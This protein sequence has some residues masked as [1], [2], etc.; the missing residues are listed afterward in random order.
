[1]TAVSPIGPAYDDGVLRITW[2]PQVNGFRLEGTVDV[3]NRSGLA[4]ALV[5]AQQGCGHVLI[6]LAALEFIDM[7]GLRLLV[8]AAR[9]LPAGRLLVLQRVPPYVRELLRVVNW[10]QTSGLRYEEMES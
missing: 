9:A 10:D 6:D 8:R 4:A 5:A 2:L 1:M 3:N 7:E